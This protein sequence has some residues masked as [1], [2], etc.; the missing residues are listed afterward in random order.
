MEARKNN[1]KETKIDQVTTIKKHK[2]E[3]VSLTNAEEN[4][5]NMY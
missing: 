2:N 1:L 5:Q 3:N 4:F